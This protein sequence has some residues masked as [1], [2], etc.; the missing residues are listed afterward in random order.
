MGWRSW[1]RLAY[2][3]TRLASESGQIFILTTFV[4]IAFIGMLGTAVDYGGVLVDRTALQNAIDAASLAAAQTLVA[5][6]TPN[7]T[8]AQTTAIQYLATNGYAQGPDTVVQVTFPPT[9]GSGALQSVQIV[10]TRTHPT[11]F[12][13]IL[14]YPTISFTVQATASA[15][16]QMVDVMLSLDLTGSMELSGTND[17][18][19]LRNAVVT[20][21][22]QMNLSPS[23]PLGAQVGMARFAG[24]MCGWNRSSSTERYINLGPGPSEYVNPCTDDETVL[25]NL[26][27]DPSPLLQLANASGGVS[28]P[29]GMSKYACPLISWTYAA[30]VV[31]HEPQFTPLGMTYNGQVQY[32]NLNPTFTGTKLPNA[33]EV[34]NNTTTGYY[35]WATANGGRNNANGEGY[36]HKVLVLITDGQDELWP[37]QGNP[38]PGVAAWDNQVVQ[39]ANQLKAGPD[40]VVGTADDVE[41]YVVGFYCTPYSTS[42]TQIPAMW[43]KSKLASTPSPHPCPGP[44]FPTAQASSID[45]LLNQISSSS[46]GSCDHYF[47]IAKTENLP[48]LFAELGNAIAWPRLTQ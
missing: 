32:G 37:T 28:C 48:Q 21:V 3:R 43:C 44:I 36:A 39:M 8:A 38:S 29:T 11:M 27:N 20:F 23:A 13:Q 30:P 26:T 1:L 5:N 2:R 6:G 14:G 35:A 15:G 45:V 19:N 16:Q 31:S 17:L 10:V 41:I 12:V 40:G 47:P 33:I 18:Q 25:S 24:I 42:T 4:M 46:P 9:P 7:T 34:V 22:N